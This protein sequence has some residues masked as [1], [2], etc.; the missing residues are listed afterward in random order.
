MRDV[1]HAAHLSGVNVLGL[2]ELWNAPFFLCTREKYPWVEF[3]EDFETGPTAQLFK[4]LS[5]KYNMVIVSPILE[6]D[7]VKETLHNSA[8]VFS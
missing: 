1:V 6:R 7:S 3:A 5:A 4:E 2:Q 8:V